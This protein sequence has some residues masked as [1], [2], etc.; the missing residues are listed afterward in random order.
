MK[1]LKKQS[2]SYGKALPIVFTVINLIAGE[3]LS[4]RAHFLFRFIIQKYNLLKNK[5]PDSSFTT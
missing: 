4:S 5:L 3:L 2:P 1:T